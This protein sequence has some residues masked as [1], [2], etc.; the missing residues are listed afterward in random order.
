MT[1]E[2]SVVVPV[3]DGASSLPALLESLVAQDLDADRYEVIVVDNA[4]RDATAEI[5]TSHGVRVVTEP[6]PNRSGARNAGARAARA[7]LFAFID[8]DCKAAPSWL[9]ALLASRGR[10]PLVAGPVLID[11]HQPPNAIERFES[12]WRFDQASAV[13]Q[14]WAATANLLVERHALEAIGGFDTTYRHIG[15]DADFCLRA[16]RKGYGIDFCESA[17][18]YH[19]AEH[20]LSPVIRRAFFHGY[21]AAQVKRRLGVG[22]VAWR[23]PRVLLSPR[24]AL[25]FHGIDPRPLTRREKV[26]QAALATATY[27]SRVGG[28]VWASLVRAR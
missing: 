16:G 17:L 5:A 10:A 24:A 28:S 3:R 18:V 23:D 1:P 26:T 22:H 12:A 6:R 25:R 9:R 8:A 21:S 19:D 4:S 11:T 14:G 27:A 7:D 13:K 2:I 15:E 20:E